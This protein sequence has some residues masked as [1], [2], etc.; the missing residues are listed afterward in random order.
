MEFGTCASSMPGELSGQTSRKFNGN[1]ATSVMTIM[2]DRF[3]N[4]VSTF[5]GLLK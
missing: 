4:L 2:T 3:G 5:P 1:R